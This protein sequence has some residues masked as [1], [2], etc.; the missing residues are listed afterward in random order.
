MEAKAKWIFWSYREYYILRYQSCL[1]SGSK[2]MQ[3]TLLHFDTHKPTCSF[4]LEYNFKKSTRLSDWLSILFRLKI[5]KFAFWFILQT[6]VNV[7]VTASEIALSVCTRPSR[8][9]VYKTEDKILDHWF[10]IAQSFWGQCLRSN[11]VTL[12]MHIWLF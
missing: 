2:K 12:L 11:S 9:W 3:P 10:T 5:I 6:F 4:T 7:C 1:T 8:V